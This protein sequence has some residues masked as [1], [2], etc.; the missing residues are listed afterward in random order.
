MNN[1]LKSTINFE[2]LGLKESFQ[3]TRFGHAFSKHV[4]MALHKK[5]SPKKIFFYQVY[6]NIFAKMHHLA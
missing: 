3:G 1:A 2:S 6:P 4:N 5:K